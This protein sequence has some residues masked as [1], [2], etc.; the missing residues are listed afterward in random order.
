[1]YAVGVDTHPVYRGCVKR[2]YEQPSHLVLECFTSNHPTNWTMSQGCH[3]VI[4]QIAIVYAYIHP[5]PYTLQ[6]TQKTEPAQIH[7]KPQH[8][9][10]RQHHLIPCSF[11]TAVN[12]AVTGNDINGVTMYEYINVRSTRPSVSDD[13]S[14]S[15]AICTTHTYGWV[16]FSQWVGYDQVGERGVR[17]AA[18]VMAGGPNGT[19]AR[20]KSCRDG[21][22][23][24][25]WNVFVGLVG[26]KDG[27]RRGR[28]R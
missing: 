23:E 18:S 27:P 16:G 17:T 4:Q 13:M 2:S 25:I 1:M 26:G 3:R 11:I 6:Y 20:T 7:Q 22:S 24:W 15:S 21:M 9:G 19:T 12:A 14:D 5:S 10:Q 28:I 8:P